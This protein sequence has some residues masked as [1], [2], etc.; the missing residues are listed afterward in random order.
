[1][2]WPTAPSGRWT[3]ARCVAGT[4]YR[5]DFEKR[6]KAVLAD[7]KQPA[8]CGSVHRRDPHGDRCRCGI[9]RRDGC[10]QP[11]QAGPGERRVAVHRVDDLPGVPGIFEKDRALARR[12]QKIDINEPTVEE[13]IADPQRA[14]DA[15][16]GTSPREVLGQGLR[17]A[18]ELSDKYINDRHMPDKAIDVID[19]AGR[20][21]PAAAGLQAQEERVGRTMSRTWSPRSPAFRRARCRPATPNRCATSSAI[22]SWSCSARTRRSRPCRRR[23]RMNRSGLGRTRNRSAA[24][25]SPGRPVSARPRSRASWR[26]SW[27]SN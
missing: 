22:C 26:R 7:L 14:E 25:C 2:C 20:G 8:G 23:S 1:M 5:G 16:R 24:S 21:Q 11:D 13:T 3:W 9:R 12:F 15:L 19:E 18:A 10:V 6:L 27:A 17:A 4:K